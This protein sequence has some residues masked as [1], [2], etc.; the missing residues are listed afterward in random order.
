MVS[1]AAYHKGQ[2]SDVTRVTVP[3]T[4]LYC[5]ADYTITAIETG[6]F[7]DDVFTYVWLPGIEVIEENLFANCPKLE[8]VDSN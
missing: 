4:V 6:V 5:S 3:E 1:I 7:A 2:S 8:E